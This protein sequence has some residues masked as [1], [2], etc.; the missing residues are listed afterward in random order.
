VRLGLWFFEV[1]AFADAA[2]LLLRAARL[3][4]DVPEKPEALTFTTQ[5]ASDEL[6]SFVALSTDLPRSMSQGLVFFR[7]ITEQV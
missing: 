4:R 6:R 1:F 2:S 3:P 5:L 7:P